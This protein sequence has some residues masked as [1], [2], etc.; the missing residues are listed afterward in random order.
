MRFRALGQ[1]GHDLGTGMIYL[2]LLKDCPE[3]VE[4]ASGYQAEKFTKIDRTFR[5]HGI[6]YEIYMPC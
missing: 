4:F 2:K 3:L 6:R 5:P 1:V